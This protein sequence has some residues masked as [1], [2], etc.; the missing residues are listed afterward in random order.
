MKKKQTVQTTGYKVRRYF[1]PTSITASQTLEKNWVRA[2]RRLMNSPLTYQ[3]VLDDQTRKVNTE[4]LNEQTAANRATALRGFL[5]ANHI[6]LE[7]VVGDEMRMLYPEAVERFVNA[8]MQE[9]KTPRS[10]S[11]TRSALKT[12]KDIIVVYDTVQAQNKEGPTPFVQALKSILENQSPTA[13]A[14]GAGIP[15]SMLFGWLRGKLPRLRNCKY[16]LRLEAYFGLHRDSLVHLSGMKTKARSE[17][18]GGGSAPLEYRDRIGT[19]TTAPFCLKPDLDSPLRHQWTDLLRYK[20]TAIPPYKRTRRGQWRFSPCPLTPDT[21][22]NWWS[23]LDGREVA[24]ARIA[25]AKISAYLGWL[26]LPQKLG[27]VGMHD[28]IVQTLA[29]IAV[30]DFLES[31]LDWSRDRIGK[32]NQ[33]AIQH[34][35]LIA[36][37]V[38]PRFG[39]LRQRRELQLTLP[40][41]YQDVDWDDLCD[42]QFEQTEQLVSAYANEVEVS[43]D[44]FAPIRHIIEMP[45]PMDAVADMVQRMRADRP[46]GNI[47]REAVWARD[48]VLIKVLSSNALRRRNLAHLTWKPDNTGDLYQRSDKSWW[49]MLPKR[50]FKNTGGAAG[51]QVYDCQVHPSAWDDIERYL[52]IFRPILMRAPTDLVFVAGTCYWS[53]EVHT[54]WTGLSERVRELTSK[55]LA[56]CDGI[57]SHAFRHL[58]AT[59]ILKADGGD[60][61]TAALALND[62]TNTVEKHYAGLRSGDAAMRIAKLLEGPFSRM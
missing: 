36:S 7:D 20:T 41:R 22:C 62:R 51:D 21:P 16:L 33:G 1:T 19:L 48:L 40:E 60:I 49:I 15:K 32:R 5:K 45:Q 61:K 28:D 3:S 29:W 25:W 46:I 17:S 39:Y 23:F 11:N 53:H 26:R 54:P 24:S 10:I 27:G 52:H 6:R 44:S 57:G 9:G 34:L 58:L 14:K 55:Y 18:V 50:K 13:V 12:W 43:R 31:F 56:N 4:N 47:K 38:R 35:A 2:Q 8:L 30:P 42:R 59:G 37:L